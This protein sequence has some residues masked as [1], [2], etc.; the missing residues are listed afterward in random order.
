MQAGVARRLTALIRSL[1]DRLV[2]NLGTSRVMLM[3]IV[4]DELRLS[5]ALK[6]VTGCLQPG[7]SSV[8]RR[9]KAALWLACTY[10][11]TAQ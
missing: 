1:T 6:W 11:P 9:S 4:T 7:K 10:Q 3:L 2:R 8:P 5:F